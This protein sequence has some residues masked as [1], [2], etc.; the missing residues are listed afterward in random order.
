MELRDALE[1][2]ATIRQQMAATEIF[3]GYRAL[4]VAGSGVLAL[5]AGFL[6][7]LFIPHPQ[8]SPGDY[9][10]FWSVVAV[11]SIAFAGLAMILRDRLRGTSAT[12]AVTWLAIG[13]FIPCLIAAAASTAV[14]FRVAPEVVWILPGL[15]QIFFSQGIFASSRL[16]PKPLIV[17]G[18]FYL[19]SGIA[20]LS[21]THG[22]AAFA[23][24]AMAVP[25]GLGQMLVAVLL[26]WTLERPHDA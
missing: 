11:L 25:F 5:V 3:R 10:F 2:I 19:L 6:Q 14:L 15:W 16:L 8:Q 9:L 23:P 7:P 21:L 13:Q 22:E 26:Y 12:R 20:V 1:S 17:A 4:P 24:W 18:I